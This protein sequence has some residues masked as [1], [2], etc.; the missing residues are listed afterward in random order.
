LAPVIRAYSM[1]QYATCECY[2][3]H[4]RIPKPA[5]YQLTIERERGRS[6]G[7]FRFYS[8]SRSTSYSTGRTYYAKKDIW[9]C[10]DCYP[11]FRSQQRR[12]ALTTFAA[13]GVIVGAVWLGSSNQSQPRL[14]SASIAS[15]AKLALIPSTNSPPYHQDQPIRSAA[16]SSARTLQIQSRLGQLGYLAD[17]PET[18][19]GSR[20]REALRAF[21]AANAMAVSDSLD[22]ETITKLFS[23]NVAYAPAPVASRETKPQ[24]SRVLIPRAAEKPGFDCAKARM[25]SARLICADAELAQLDGT[26]GITFQKRKRQI[27][28]SDQ[29]NLVLEQNA[30]ITERD[31]L[32]NLVGK[33]GASID[34]LADSKACLVSEIKS[35]IAVLTQRDQRN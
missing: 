30:W 13:V 24:A 29:S 11:K 26:L 8:K 19:R 1:A 3:C 33:D 34:A 22:D 9:L 4:I 25:A 18:T 20:S 10:Q 31:T 27:S 7:S 17:Q 23:S 32:C 5:A 6:G 15:A 2:I 21:K 14:Q 12:R 16:L 28:T 35:R